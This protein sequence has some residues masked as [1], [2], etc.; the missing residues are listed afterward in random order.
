MHLSGFGSFTWKCYRD[1][2]LQL[3]HFI[4]VPA[5]LTLQAH[6]IEWIKYNMQLVICSRQY[7]LPLYFPSG[8]VQFFLCRNLM[9]FGRK[10]HATTTQ[11]LFCHSPPALPCSCLV[12]CPFFRWNLQII[13]FSFRNDKL[14][15]AG[16]EISHVFDW[17]TSAE[18]T[19][20]WSCFSF[21]S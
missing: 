9:F 16:H 21:L 5:A 19:M 20:T 17:T 15:C 18:G 7:G 3:V 8:K 2:M 1:L 10:C 11:L 14:Q 6:L 4:S 13:L 12:N